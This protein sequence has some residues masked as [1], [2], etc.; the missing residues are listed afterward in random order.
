MCLMLDK[1][2]QHQ[3]NVLMKIFEKQ[4]V[5]LRALAGAGKTYILTYL[6]LQV[7]KD[8]DTNVLLVTNTEALVFHVVKWLWHRTKYYMRAALLPRIHYLCSPFCC[9]PRRITVDAGTGAMT[10][11]HIPLTPKTSYA[12][13]VIDEAHHCT[14]TKDQLEFIQSHAGKSKFLA[15]SDLSQADGGSAYLPTDMTVHIHAHC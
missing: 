6:L 2:T 15:C 1:P 9:G 4:P 14:Q 5:H 11:E 13:T 10:T 3:W 8:K 7:L 12:Y